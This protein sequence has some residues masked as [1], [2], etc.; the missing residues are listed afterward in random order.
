MINS[1][2]RQMWANRKRR[3]KG[4]C[5]RLYPKMMRDLSYVVPYEHKGSVL[6]CTPG[7]QGICLRMYSLVVIYINSM[8]G[9]KITKSMN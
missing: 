2:F 9:S 8:A 3:P 7:E 5:L 1:E 6:G 4:I